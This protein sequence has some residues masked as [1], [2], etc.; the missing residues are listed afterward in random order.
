MA[1]TAASVSA[2]ATLA[3]QQLEIKRQA[4]VSF[5]TLINTWNAALATALPTVN[6]DTRTIL[7]WIP[8]GIALKNSLPSTADQTFTDAGHVAT[9]LYRTMRAIQFARTA[10][11]ISAAQNTALLAAYNT[12][13]ATA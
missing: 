8:V 1:T 11:R 9:W 6:A 5:V 10:N 2:G 4:A 3:Q 12:V 13:W 7:N